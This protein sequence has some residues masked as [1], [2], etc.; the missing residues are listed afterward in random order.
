MQ[1]RAESEVLKGSSLAQGGVTTDITF[2][3]QGAPPFTT[4]F[5]RTCS[6]SRSSFRV[7]LAQSHA[8]RGEMIGN[9][10]Y[11]ESHGCHL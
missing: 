9:C 2:S 4:D 1:T 3:Y 8:G 5:G 6:S 7:Q 11:L 10:S